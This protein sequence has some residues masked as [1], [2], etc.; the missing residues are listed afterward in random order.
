MFLYK[1]RF[2]YLLCVLCMPLHFCDT[3]AVQL[4]ARHGD[5]RQASV[6]SSTLLWKVSSCHGHYIFFCLINSDLLLS[7]VDLIHYTDLCA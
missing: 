3:V 5:H 2:V 6:S 7:V 4:V 1:A